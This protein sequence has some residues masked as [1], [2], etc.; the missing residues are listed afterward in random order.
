MAP[1]GISRPGTQQQ[2]ATEENGVTGTGGHQT[3]I[4]TMLPNGVVQK[5]G[6]HLA[7]ALE[8]G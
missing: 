6:T 5:A 3:L 8:Q 1:C 4:G 7:L 2:Q